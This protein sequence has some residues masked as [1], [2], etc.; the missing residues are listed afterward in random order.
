MQPP[1]TIEIRVP[2][3]SIAKTVQHYCWALCGS[4]GAVALIV[5]ALFLYRAT[6]VVESLPDRLMATIRD[7]G[8]LTRDWAT[9]SRDDV[10]GKIV[11]LLDK[12]LSGARQDAR[13]AVIDIRRDALR[14]ENTVNDRLGQVITLTDSH[15]TG[16]RAEVNAQ[17]SKVN[18]NL[19]EVT[20]PT[21]LFMAQVNDAAPFWLDCQYNPNCLF[22]RWVGTARGIEQFTLAM[23][24][25]S[26]A[27][28]GALNRISQDVSVVT[29]KFV[30]PQPW[31]HK[32]FNLVMGSANLARLAK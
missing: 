15:L 19:G 16:M 20:R 22:N 8:A 28:L 9:E 30:E 21:G 11:P 17:L 5:L 18:D 3:E 31:Y 13:N 32:L 23:G 27:T 14:T 6:A 12:Q 10:L 4:A 7:Q 26:P 2:P 25:N 24:A 1:E 29:R